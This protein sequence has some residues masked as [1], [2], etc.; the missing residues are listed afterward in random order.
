MIFGLI[1]EDPVTFNYI[2]CPGK[3]S[4]VS[5]TE[6]LLYNQSVVT[7]LFDGIE[8]SPIFIEYY[9]RPLSPRHFGSVRKLFN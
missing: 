5:L 7:S 3:K 6:T 1:I 9:M 2:Y 4:P 8:P